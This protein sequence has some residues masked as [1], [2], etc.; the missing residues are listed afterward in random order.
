MSDPFGRAPDGT[1]V[2]RIRIAG[3]GLT[4]WIITWGAS[5]QDLRMDGIAPSLVLGSDDLSAYLG[6]MRYYG[7]VVGPVANRIALGRFVLDGQ[8]YDLDRNEAGQTTLHGGA[9][10]FGCRNWTVTGSGPDWVSLALHHPDGLGG[11]PG[12]MVV[13]VTYRLG[14]DS[15]LSVEMTGL[16][17]APTYFSPAFH[18]YWNL[19]GQADLRDHLFTVAAETYLPVDDR[20]IPLGDPAPV[21][22]TVFDHR[23]PHP[24]TG[25]IDHNYCLTGDQP[26]CRLETDALALEVRT[27]QPGLQVYDAGRTD[28]APAVGHGGSPYGEA[29]GVALE[30][31]MW[32]DSP[33]HPAYPSN[34]LM[35][36]QT[37]RQ[38]SEFRLIRKA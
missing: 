6:P 5:L 34:L 17:D 38:M 15:T 4:A 31:Q 7:A 11:F 16:T 27:D 37:Y 19:S 24:L 13:T 28:T 22:G 33:N 25:Q 1:P 32:P 10:G 18:G 29:A 21:A 23:T 26:I 14:P 3:G 12:N 9:D 2:R 36:G 8:T 30:P 35:P 20:M